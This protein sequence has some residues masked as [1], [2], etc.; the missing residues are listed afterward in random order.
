MLLVLLRSSSER[1]VHAIGAS[2]NANMPELKSLTAL[3]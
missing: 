2:F 3:E 1:A